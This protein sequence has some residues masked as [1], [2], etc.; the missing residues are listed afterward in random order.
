MDVGF[1]A[2]LAPV[3]TAVVMGP[4]PP[5]PTAPGN[6]PS[7][8]PLGCGAD[9]TVAVVLTVGMSAPT[10]TGSANPCSLKLDVR[11]R[12]LELPSVQPGAKS[13]GGDAV[14]GRGE[15]TT[16]RSDAGPSQAAVAKDRMDTRRAAS[17]GLAV[18]IAGGFSP[19]MDPPS[20]MAMRL[21]FCDTVKVPPVLLASVLSSPMMTS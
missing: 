17:G 9:N 18:A 15:A 8:T 20:A 7:C 14:C 13:P 16:G 11:A 3:A 10:A 6:G 2:L 21:A 1:S 19:V 12:G 4:T 5:L